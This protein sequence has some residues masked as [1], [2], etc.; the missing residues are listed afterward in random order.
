[1]SDNASLFPFAAV[2][3]TAFAAVFFM[4]VTTSVALAFI[5]A[6]FIWAAISGTAFWIRRKLRIVHRHRHAS[7]RGRAGHTHG[8]LVS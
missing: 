8:R 3:L 1:M 6:L 7:L 2:G 4:T 5:A